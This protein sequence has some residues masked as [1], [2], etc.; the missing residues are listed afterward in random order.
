MDWLWDVPI[1]SPV[2]PPGQVVEPMEDHGSHCGSCTSLT[3]CCTLCL[4]VLSTTG[5]SCLLSPWTTSLWKELSKITRT[6]IFQ[7]MLFLSS[8][9]VTEMKNQ[10]PYFQAS[11]V[12]HVT[13]SEQRPGLG[14]LSCQAKMTLANTTKVQTW[15]MPSQLAPQAANTWPMGLGR[16]GNKVP[17]SPHYNLVA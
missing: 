6:R 10:L 9:S 4:W 1:G 17:G 14:N 3:V 13:K 15:H 8:I 2:F 11:R 7:L 5:W 12:I 16:E